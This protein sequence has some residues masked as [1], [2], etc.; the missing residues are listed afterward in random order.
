LSPQQWFE[1]QQSLAARGFNPG[2]IDGRPGNKTRHAIRLFQGAT[3][4]P[5]TGT[6]TAAQIEQLLTRQ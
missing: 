2:K 6:L 5:V 3:N 4:Q 1:I